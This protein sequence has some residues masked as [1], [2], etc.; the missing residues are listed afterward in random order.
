MPT[1]SSSE[2][3]SPTPIA[4]PQKTSSNEEVVKMLREIKV[5]LG[6][7]KDLQD[8]LT[9]LREKNTLLEERCA[10]EDEK[11]NSLQE[12]V[13]T[14][15]SERKSALEKLHEHEVARGRERENAQSQIDSSSTELEDLQKRLQEALTAKKTLECKVDSLTQSCETHHARVEALEKERAD[16]EERVE[17]ERRGI[18]SNCEKNIQD[19]GFLLK[20]K[21]ESMLSKKGALDKA[22]GAALEAS[23]KDKDA[24]MQRL[25]KEHQTTLQEQKQSLEAAHRVELDSVKADLERKQSQAQNV[26]HAEKA[27][28][29]KSCEEMAGQLEKAKQVAEMNLRSA[30]TRYKT[31]MTEKCQQLQDEANAAVDRLTEENDRKVQSIEREK[32]EALLELETYKK[33]I[34]QRA[35]T[36]SVALEA[37]QPT[38]FIPGQRDQRRTSDGG[39]NAEPTP[40]HQ[41]SPLE[42]GGST[43]ENVQPSLYSRIA[44]IFSLGI[45]DNNSGGV[46]IFQDPPSSCGLS[47]MRPSISPLTEGSVLAEVEHNRVGAQPPSI[48][49]SRGV[50]HAIIRNEHNAPAV[51]ARRFQVANTRS[52]LILNPIAQP[53][54]IDSRTSQYAS[55]GPNAQLAPDQRGANLALNQERRAEC[56]Q[57]SKASNIPRYGL[58]AQT[59]ASH[60]EHGGPVYHGGPIESYSDA[61]SP[62]IVTAIGGITGSLLQV[63][64]ASGSTNRRSKISNDQSPIASNR[65]RVASP[66]KQVHEE[67]RS[68]ISTSRKATARTI[69]TPAPASTPAS[70]RQRKDLFSTPQNVRKVSPKSVGHGSQ[71]GKGYGGKI[72][73]HFEAGK[74]RS[75][76]RQSATQSKLTQPPGGRPR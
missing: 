12:Q 68:R 65:K 60:Q 75:S 8:Q 53:E 56:F 19:A 74:E 70:Q 61:S 42:Y 16:S 44:N 33:E 24:V 57:W 15:K 26:W 6:T 45:D 9:G 76:Q 20:S 5:D 54:V 63:E 34:N 39:R 55:T 72:A 14:A 46:Q 7:A 11:V 3:G 36:G 29:D 32:N 13:E 23:L 48:T 64:R 69:Q 28:S 37:Y 66:A 71:S 50:K 4:N 51:H 43:K 35:I 17:K 40:P 49:G 52:K 62:H 58:T 1:A 41:S 10:Q 47:E 27:E 18:Q 25:V 21:Y 31:D 30:E 59:L 67:K 38:G 22:I 2:S 73:A